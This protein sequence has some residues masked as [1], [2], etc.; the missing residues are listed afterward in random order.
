MHVNAFIHAYMYI[1]YQ[2]PSRVL[3]LVREFRPLRCVPLVAPGLFESIFDV[4]VN[5]NNTE[6]RFGYSHNFVDAA[7]ASPPCSAS[8]SSCKLPAAT[9]IVMFVA[10]ACVGS[11]RT[12]AFTRVNSNASLSCVHNLTLP[13]MKTFASILA[14]SLVATGK[15]LKPQFQTPKRNP[16]P[17]TLK[18][19][20]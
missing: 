20:I 14:L 9:C 16:Q 1:Y 12:T 19:K 2:H 8:H 4:C 11:C 10:R 15:G 18:P 17:S 13:A 6:T 3:M 7:A 5:V